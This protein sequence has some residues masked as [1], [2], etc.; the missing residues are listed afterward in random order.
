MIKILKNDSKFM[1]TLS[2]IIDGVILN[3]LF[4]ICCIP[5]ITIGAAWTSL[6]Y[7]SVKVIRNSR[8]YMFK[9]FVRGIKDN[10]VLA[11]LGWCILLVVFALS[12]CGAFVVF[13]S[14][15]GAI[16]ACIMALYFAVF[17]MAL[18]LGIY[19]FPALS[20]YKMDLKNMFTMSLIMASKHVKSTILLTFEM[21][22]FLFLMF[23]GFTNYPILLFFVPEC[24]ILV[25]SLTMEKLLKEFMVYVED[26]AENIENEDNEESAEL[27][28][29]NESDDEDEE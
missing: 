8:G 2:K 25:I 18:V 11:T 7:S 6:Y 23:I 27:T 16:G 12:G 24:A 21:L 1:I 28:E 17:M 3:I 29:D 20:R 4:L 5:I 22:V 14:M 26:D 10:F 19:M 9:E 15:H 13:K